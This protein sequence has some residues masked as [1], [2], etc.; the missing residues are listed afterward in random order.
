MNLF[1]HNFVILIKDFMPIHTINYIS[2]D[3]GSAT[4]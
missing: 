3:N 1:K 2:Q 4:N